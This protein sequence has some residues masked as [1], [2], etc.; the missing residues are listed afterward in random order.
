MRK[1]GSDK[2]PPAGYSDRAQKNELSPSPV[3]PYLAGISVLHTMDC[4]VRKSSV[5]RQ[6]FP[7]FIAIMTTNTMSQLS[8]SSGDYVVFENTLINES[9]RS[10]P[11]KTLKIK[12]PVINGSDEVV[13]MEDLKDGEVAMDQTCRAA[14][15]V[16]EGDSV[17]VTISIT[18]VFAIGDPNP[19]YWI[20]IIAFGVWTAWSIL[21]SSTYKTASSELSF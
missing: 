15:S 10:Q 2:C 19:L 20:P 17:K 13:E 12:A 8:I 9:D 14:I 4:I 16:K 7:D 18:A 11:P 5:K 1:A 3:K 6:P 21:T